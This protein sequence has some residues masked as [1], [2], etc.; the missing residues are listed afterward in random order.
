MSKLASNIID[1]WP[2]FTKD[3]FEKCLKIWLD[4]RASLLVIM[5]VLGSSI[6]D[7]FIEN[8]GYK[9]DILRFN[10]SHYIKIVFV[11]VTKVIA[12]YIQFSTL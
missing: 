10:S 6:I 12:V 1:K 8:K 2:R 9:Q 5:L 3:F 7:G 4:D 11:L